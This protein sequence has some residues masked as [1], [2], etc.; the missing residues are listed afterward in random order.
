M[1]IVEIK[2][3]LSIERFDS[4]DSWRGLYTLGIISRPIWLTV[5][6]QQSRAADMAISFINEISKRAG[7]ERSNGRIRVGIV[8]A[9][10]GGMTLAYCLHSYLS[11]GQKFSITVDVFEKHGGIC[12]IQRGCQTRRI[13]PTL[14]Y[15]PDMGKSDGFTVKE[16]LPALVNSS[17][18]WSG[19]ISAGELAS[20]LSREYFDR[21]D[22]YREKRGRNAI[23]VYEGC[24]YLFVEKSVSGVYDVTFQGH[25]IKDKL[26][27]S[28]PV[29]SVGG[30]DAVFCDRVWC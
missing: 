1:K 28:E 12:P 13:H 4:I 30:Y 15:W 3:V 24:G 5:S 27:N 7:S 22:T 16:L 21:F 14:Q 2:D 19:G 18:S 11:R 20:R 26:G 9:G 17:L 6:S 29:S 23:R 25:R 10:V 8:G